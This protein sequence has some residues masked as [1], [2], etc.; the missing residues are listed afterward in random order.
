MSGKPL[1]DQ[2]L[3]EHGF[4]RSDDGVWILDAEETFLLCPTHKGP[5]QIY[6]LTIGQTV[7][8]EIDIESIGQV[9][10]LAKWVGYELR[11]VRDLAALRTLH[12]G[13]S[14]AKAI[15]EHL[16]KEPRS[17]TDIESRLK[18]ENPVEWE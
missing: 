16:A 6:L 11:K 15:A 7:I 14:P 3:F 2:W 17:L 5:P 12:A 13:K 18:S 10:L 4:D 9:V 1:T 8:W